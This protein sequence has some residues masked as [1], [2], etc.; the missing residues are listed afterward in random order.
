MGF[1]GGSADKGA[2]IITAVAWITTM[3]RVPSLVQGLP[4]A[5]DVAKKK[6][7]PHKKT[8]KKTKILR[9]IN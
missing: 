4:N 5:V 3:A 9:F 7:K 6:Q 2:S 8:N 1:L